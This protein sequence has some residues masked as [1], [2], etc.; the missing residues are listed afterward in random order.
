[1][2]LWGCGGGRAPYPPGRERP[3]A[4]PAPAAPLFP[5]L[6]ATHPLPPATTPT[7]H[8]IAPPQYNTNVDVGQNVAMI[9]SLFTGSTLGHKTDIADGS[10]RGY[11]FRTFEHIQG[12]YYIAPRFLDKVAVR[13][14]LGGRLGG[15]GEWCTGQAG[16]MGGRGG[17]W[18]AVLGRGVARAPAP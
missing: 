18:R 13:R 15:G 8:S 6:G 7:P 5:S 17:C 14:R 12:D 2:S 4:G 10:L 16:C 1:M 11:E 3:A 9:D